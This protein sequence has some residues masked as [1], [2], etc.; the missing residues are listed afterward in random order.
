LLVHVLYIWYWMFLQFALHILMHSLGTSYCKCCFC[1]VYLFAKGGLLC[2]VLCFVYGKL[3][4][5]MCLARV[6]W[7]SLLF[8]HSELLVFCTLTVVRYSK[9]I[10]ERNVS[11]TGS[12]PVLRWGGHLLCWVP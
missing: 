6:L 3:L 10:R 7:L 8:F 5:F 4:L 2:F 11:E 1:Y 12:V 9:N